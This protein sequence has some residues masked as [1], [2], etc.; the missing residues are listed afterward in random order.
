MTWFV[1]R[2]FVVVGAWRLLRLH[3]DL[4]QLK[5]SRESVSWNFAPHGSA[6][7]S[8]TPFILKMKY[9][10]ARRPELSDKERIIKHRSLTCK[11]MVMSEHLFNLLHLLQKPQIP[12]WLLIWESFSHDDSP[13]EAMEVPPDEETQSVLNR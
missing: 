6:R 11:I 7:E 8:S 13:E 2:V 9:M 1:F 4:R 5:R 3:A 12:A 10:M